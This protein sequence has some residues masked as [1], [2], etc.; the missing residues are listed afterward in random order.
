VTNAEALRRDLSLH[1]DV[2]FSFPFGIAHWIRL[3]ARKVDRSR[4]VC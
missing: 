4:A 3:G 2:L 1:N